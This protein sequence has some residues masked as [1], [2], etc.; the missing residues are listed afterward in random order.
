MTKLVI[1]LSG[2]AVT[3]VAAVLAVLLIAPLLFDGQGVRDAVIERA[4]LATGRQ[5]HINGSVGLSLISGPTLI[6][7]DVSLAE[8]ET[9]DLL[10]PPPDALLHMDDLRLVLAPLDMLHGALTATKVILT[11]P[12]LVLERRNGLENWRFHPGS[13]TERRLRDGSP[14]AAPHDLNSVQQHSLTFAVTEIAIEGGEVAIRGALSFTGISARATQ[15][16]LNVPWIGSA[17]GMSGE[18]R[19][20]AHGSVGTAQASGDTPRA[21]DIT[22]TSDN[23]GNDNGRFTGTLIANDSDHLSAQGSLALSLG[24]ADMSA[25]ADITN[26]HLSL[27]ALTIARGPLHADGAVRG[28]WPA[29]KPPQ[30][31]A[32]FDILSLDLDA[33]EPL[34]DGKPDDQRDIASLSTMIPPDVTLAADVKIAAIR[35]HGGIMADTAAHL[36]WTRDGLSLESVR[37]DGPGSATI[38]AR[39]T[40]SGALSDPKVDLQAELRSNDLRDTASWLGFAFPSGIAANRLNRLAVKG[41]L[42]G[43]AGNYRADDLV[44]T[45]DSLPITG[46]LSRGAD[47]VSVDLKTTN[48]VAVD[49]Y[50][51]NSPPPLGNAVSDGIFTTPPPLYF[52]ISAAGV[53]WRSET[54]GHPLSLAGT[55]PPQKADADLTRISDLAVSLAAGLQVFTGGELKLYR[56]DGAWSLEGQWNQASLSAH[57]NAR[58]GSGEASVH[59]PTAGGAMI[60]THDLPGG[61]LLDVL[62]EPIAAAAGGKK[63]PPPL[64]SIT[65][66]EARWLM[67]GDTIAIRPLT[68]Q[69]PVYRVSVSGAVNLARHG[70]DLQGIVD[71]HHTPA[72]PNALETVSASRLALTVKGGLTAPQASLAPNSDTP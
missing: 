49:D 19:W 60:D 6:L 39:G 20:S 21:I 34:P 14:V 4:T 11:H 48:T 37:A 40:V 71:V 30:I 62:M 7:R 2:V 63:P 69:T 65:A 29:G 1:V 35:W 38:S 16:S 52:R 57:G 55:F 67:T 26:N 10:G 24:G 51:S 18:R 46:A 58:I 59:A 13:A 44:G 31:A 33:T 8:A 28:D 15:S 36:R 53:R 12:K 42:R 64:G 27:S 43:Q 41:H 9:D 23:G 45:L 54:L 25:K 61:H 22:I 68:V 70:V 32:S 3:L 47:G 56:G 72:S 50:L 17:A 5:L 66:I